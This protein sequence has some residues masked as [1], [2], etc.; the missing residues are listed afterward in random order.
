MS[1]FCYPKK[2]HL[3]ALLA[4]T[5]ALST[6]NAHN[7]DNCNSKFFSNALPS[8]ASTLGTYHV[9]ANG[10]FGQAADVAYPVNATS[11]PAL[12]TVIINFTS[13][14]TSSYTFGH[15]LPKDWNQRFIAV[16]N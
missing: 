15:S 2:M 6:I 13:S 16:G 7:D 3:S 10:S 5:T 12:C 4:I 1:R 8:N 11:L 14:E 9:S